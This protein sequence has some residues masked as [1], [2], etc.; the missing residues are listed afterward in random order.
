MAE[1]T[2]IARPYAQAAFELAREQGTLAKWSEA[3]AL[4]SAVATDGG[5]RKLIGSPR[6]TRGQLADLVI[7]ICGTRL[8]DAARNFVRVLAD[9]G[10]L[11]VLPQ[12]AALF[13]ALRAEAEGVIEADMVSAFAVDEAQ[14]SGIAAALKARLG[15]EVTLTCSVDPELIGGAVI[16]AGDL[17]IDGSVKGKLAKL[18]SAL[19]H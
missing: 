1:T 10:R 15:R 7:D 6:V 2:T 14:K 11:G 16:R 18:A 19:N 13:E 4:A 3:L 17:V 12:I 5:I 8:D 9:N